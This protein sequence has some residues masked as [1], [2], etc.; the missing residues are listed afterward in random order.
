MYCRLMVERVPLQSLAHT[1]HSLMQLHGLRKKVTLRQ[2][3]NLLLIL[4]QQSALELSMAFQCL[5]FVT[6]K[7]FAQRQI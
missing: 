7:M 1:S 5:I 2:E 6:K 4:S 3:Q